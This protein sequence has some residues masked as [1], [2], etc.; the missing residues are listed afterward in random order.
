MTTPNLLIP[1]RSSP[2]SRWS[3]AWLLIAGLGAA[4]PGC[5]GEP[6][7]PADELATAETMDDVALR[8]TAALTTWQT[9]GTGV[10]YRGTGNPGNNAFLAYAGYGYSDAQAQAWLDALYTASLSRLNIGHLYAVR[11]PADVGYARRE[12]GNTKLI[13]HLLPRLDAST[14]LVVVAAHSSGS[15]VAN[16]LFGFLYAG[17]KDSAGKTANKTV[18][19]NLDGGTGLTTTDVNNLYKTYFV[20]TKD[21]RTGTRSPNASVMISQ[22]TS[23]GA[24]VATIQLAGDAAGCAATGSWCLHMTLITNKPHSMTGMDARDYT[25][26]AGRPVQSGYLDQT[27]SILDGLAK[28]P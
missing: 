24:R 8:A 5:G 14:K 19:Y 2:R 6:L 23:F 10:S 7:A 25:D 11:G 22:A 28:R 13:A 27:W 3:F 18:Y 15:Y 1:K 17:G 26:F 21:G 9:I 4:T 16:E 20:Y 12:I